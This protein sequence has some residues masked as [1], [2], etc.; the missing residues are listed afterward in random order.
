MLPLRPAAQT[1]SRCP[2]ARDAHAAAIAAGA[3]Q[4][5]RGAVGRVARLFYPRLR[6][7]VVVVGRSSN[8]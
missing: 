7:A 4:G 5:I 2:F 1:W 8:S 3:G 6:A